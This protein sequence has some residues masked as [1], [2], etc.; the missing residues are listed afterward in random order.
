MAESTVI[1]SNELA[2][3]FSDGYPVSAGHMLIVPRMHTED[4]FR[5]TPEE[6]AAILS[7]VAPV[8]SYIETQH[9]PDT[10]LNPHKDRSGYSCP[11]R[12]GFLVETK[13]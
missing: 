5:L 6:Q 8:R 2:V 12:T 11:G 7:L 3:A 10:A 1:L 13:Y 4:F 9:T